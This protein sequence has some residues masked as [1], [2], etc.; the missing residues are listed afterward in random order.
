[1]NRLKRLLAS[2]LSIRDERGSALVAGIMILMIISMI[3][4]AVLQSSDVQSHQTG[5]EVGGERGFNLAES[6]LDAEASLVERNWATST[7]QY[8]VCTQTSTATTTCPAGSVGSGYSTSYAGSRF[9][10]PTWSVQ[11]I[12]DNWTSTAQ[13]YYDDSA[14]S[15]SLLTHYDSNG[16][17]KLWIRADATI[18]GQHRIVVAQ[19]VRQAEVVSLPQNV[20]TSGAVTTSNNGNKIIIEAK[21]PNSGLTGTVDLRCGNS[22]T[23]PSYGSSCAGWDPSKG[24]LDPAGAW[25]TGYVDPSGNFQTLSDQTLGALRA[26][27]QA[28]GTYYPA[29]Q[30]PPLGQAGLL[31]IENANCT[32]TGTGGT[33]WNS[34][35]APGAIIVA[36]GTLTFNANVSFYGIIYMANNQQT[37]VP[38]SGPCTSGSTV[39]TVHGG[40]ALHGGLFVDKCGTVDAGDKA[41]DIVYDTKA[42]GGLQAFATPSLAQNT[43]RIVGN[44]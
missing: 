14:L 23:Q 1:M 25:Q 39:F 8:G 28:S 6:A 20:I 37:T 7:S 38:S 15:S 32:Y 35:A 24:Q 5:H 22:N 21:D 2:R 27:A 13:S 17:N 19:V 3:G 40:G 29:G 26:A 34:D 36:T 41:F 18:N 31:F 33:N 10:S 42:F 12:D 9:A 30:C 16:N 11:V 43:F 44:R 4:I